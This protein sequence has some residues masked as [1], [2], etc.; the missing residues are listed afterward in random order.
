MR[1][2]RTPPGLRP[3][4]L[5]ALRLV[6]A[7]C[8]GRLEGGEAGSTCVALTPGTLRAG[9]HTADTRTAGSCMLLAQ[10]ALPC[11]LFAEGGEEGSDE[12]GGSA[13]AGGGGG[14][15]SGDRAAGAESAASEPAMG[16]G[17]HEPAPQPP[18]SR[19]VLRGGTDASMAPPVGYLQEVLLPTLHR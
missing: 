3:Q 14:G 2:G 12:G 10:A 5:T 19:L 7:L 15:D 8:G 11:L 13:S 17:T 18:V 4:H 16:G 9:E 6:A 1:A